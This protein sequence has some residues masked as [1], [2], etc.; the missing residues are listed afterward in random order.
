MNFND[1]RGVL[2]DAVEMFFKGAT[3]MW[4]EQINTK[5]ALPYITLK[6]GGI[7]KTTFP[8]K[9]EDG[10]RYYPC[11]TIM[12]INLY[13][14]GKPV[15]VEENVT[16]N[17]A[18]TA[19]SDLMDFFKFLES[20]N[21]VDYLAD[22]GID[23]MLTPPVRDLTELLNESR[24]RYRSMAEATVSWSEDAGGDY[25]IIGM[26]SIPNSSGGG[27]VEM[28]ETEDNIIEEIELNYYT[29]GGIDNN[30]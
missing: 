30:D 22:K 21:M 3:V 28:K 27:T 18:N 12:E 7:N 4:S 1:V 6:T 11:S 24:Y 9:D 5:P 8:I 14:K 16:G 20:D 23:I 26:P 17:Y 2:Y 19:V 10:N 29:E 25:G 13:T 15:T